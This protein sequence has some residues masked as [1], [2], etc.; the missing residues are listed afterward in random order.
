MKIKQKKKGVLFLALL[1]EPY[2]TLFY[3]MQTFLRPYLISMFQN[4]LKTRC[5]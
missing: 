5:I 2:I 4:F 3:L 1:S